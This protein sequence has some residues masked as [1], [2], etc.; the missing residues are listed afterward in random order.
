MEPEPRVVIVGAGPTGLTLAVQLLAASI[1]FRLID[2]AETAVHESRAL[3]IQARTLEVLE[4]DGIAS[5]LVERGDTARL[6][7]MHGSRT[8]DLSLFDSGDAATKYPFLLFLSQAET[9]RILAEH[10]SAR[11]VDIERGTTLV[12]LAQTRDEVQLIVR[13]PTGE[14]SLSADYVVGCDGSHSAVRR[15]AG[16]EFAGRGFPQTFVIADVE[17]DGLEPGPVHS[18]IAEAG[19]LFFFPLGEPTTWRALGMAPNDTEGD[20][21]LPALQS[22]VD[23]FVGD[24]SLHV[25]DPAWLTRFKVQSRHA[26]RFRAGRVLL[27][28]DAAHIHS[29]AGAQGMN[30]GIQ[31]AANLSWKLAQVIRGSAPMKLLETYEEERLPIALG[32]LRMT[33]RLFD[34]A[35]TGNPLVRWARP[36]IAPAALNA[37]R[38]LGWIRSIGFRVI[39][40]ISISYRRR[41]IARSSRSIRLGRLRAGDRLP[42]L[43][44]MV[45][46]ARTD[47]RE[48]VPTP[49]YLLAAIGASGAKVGDRGDHVVVVEGEWPPDAPGK[50]RW[51]LIRPDGYI[52]GIWREPATVVAFLKRWTTSG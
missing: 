16:I 22:I 39:S 13:T 1:P 19:I 30:T 29:P 38:N 20:P 23:S 51:L 26:R 34:M 52:A 35:T 42:P 47:L 8:V 7:R 44:I 36:R 4:R 14:E 28:G 5:R 11:G 10:L 33:N 9:E 15:L 31:D 17:V 2:T 12:G 41:A 18:F 45:N 25:R 50:E 32:V 46:G 3:A 37:A 48:L 40:Q 43:F 24:R 27:A 6:I 49:R 21:D